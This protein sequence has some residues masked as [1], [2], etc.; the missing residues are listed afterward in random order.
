VHAVLR[1]DLQALLAGIGLVLHE[2]IHACGA[3]ALLGAGELGQ[4][5]AT[6]TL[7]SLSVR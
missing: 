7:A 5:H 4:V 3:V 1:I 6:G 2:L